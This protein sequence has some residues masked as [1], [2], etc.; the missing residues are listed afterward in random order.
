MC[1]FVNSS[2]KQSD[3]QSLS[4][5]PLV[6]RGTLQK[7]KSPMGGSPRPS[8]SLAGEMGLG[9]GSIRRLTD[10]KQRHDGSLFTDK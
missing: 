2:P 9:G 6:A 4:Q 1:Y 10:S 8:W 7:G 5:L 3:T